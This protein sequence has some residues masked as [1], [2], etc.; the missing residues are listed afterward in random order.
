[1]RVKPLINKFE[2]K[3]KKDRMI[4]TV[5]LE[6]KAELATGDIETE[7]MMRQFKDCISKMRMQSS[8]LLSQANGFGDKL[9]QIISNQI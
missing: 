7:E 2:K 4:N 3:T 6:K 9:D 1:M 8:N 5:N